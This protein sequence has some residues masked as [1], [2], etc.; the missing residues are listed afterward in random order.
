MS[1]SRRDFTRAVGSTAALLVLAPHLTTA[2]DQEH[3]APEPYGEMT[4]HRHLAFMRRGVH[5]HVWYR[6]E[7]VT[8]RC[9]FADDRGRGY[10]VLFLHKD[11]R[12][13]FDRTA[14]RPGPPRAAMETVYGITMRPGAPFWATGV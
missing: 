12:P 10:A 9:S 6:G 8:T 7:D 1:L 3:P 14:S 2:S 5:L 13:Y 4:V 11:G